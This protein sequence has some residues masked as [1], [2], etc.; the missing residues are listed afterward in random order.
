MDPA[1]IAKPWKR[2]LELVKN[3]PA[4]DQPEVPEIAIALS[5]PAN[6]GVWRERFA[7]LPPA[8]ASAALALADFFD[9]LD[10]RSTPSID[11]RGENP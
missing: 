1:S 6:R 8:S 9:A 4:M 10:L 3:T 11:N 7:E 5:S 2:W